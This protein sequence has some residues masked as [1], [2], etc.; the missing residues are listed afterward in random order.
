MGLNQQSFIHII[1][2]AFIK[3]NIRVLKMIKDEKYLQYN[4]S[5]R[6]DK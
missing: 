1:L 6:Y 3:A 2:V 4:K 5:K